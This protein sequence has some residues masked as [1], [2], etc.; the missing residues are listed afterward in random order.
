MPLGLTLTKV[1][2]DKIEF[3]GTSS[4]SNLTLNTDPT[5]NTGGYEDLDGL[6]TGT[7]DLTYMVDSGASAETVD[8]DFGD[9][10]FTIYVVA[11]ATSN[12]TDIFEDIT[13]P[14]FRG[15]K[16]A[17]NPFSVD[18]TGFANSGISLVTVLM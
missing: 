15:F 7:L 10:E 11:L 14:Q 18:E 9:H 4:T 5:D 1:E 6:K 12:P 8:L 16:D 3:S 17:L 13:E 2:G